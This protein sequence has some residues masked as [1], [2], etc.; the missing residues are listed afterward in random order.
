MLH[1][2]FAVMAAC[3]AG[4]VAKDRSTN[5]ARESW[6]EDSSGLRQGTRSAWY[7]SG[8]PWFVGEYRAGKRDGA[9]KLW[10]DGGG[11]MATLSY[12]DDRAHGALLRF[13]ENGQKS[14]QGECR[15]GAPEGVWRR[16]WPNGTVEVES[17]F[18]D[19][20]PSGAA[21]FYSRRGAPLPF[22][23]YVAEKRAKVPP[24][25]EQL[26]GDCAD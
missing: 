7:A 14:A 1:L 21:S 26:F 9:W 18:K 16:Y 15:A 13:F 2:V 6:C 19:G 20:K 23:Q 24:T 10:Y 8:K 22:E 25:V 17:T 5:D 3:P 4:S 11:V 12:S